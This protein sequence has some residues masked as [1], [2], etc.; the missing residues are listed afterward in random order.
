[1][2]ERCKNTRR[3]KVLLNI[4]IYSLLIAFDPEVK[5]NLTHG[6]SAER[7]SKFPFAN[8]AARIEFERPNFKL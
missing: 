3:N 2:L 6:E 1:M 7:L 8:N 4:H 5:T